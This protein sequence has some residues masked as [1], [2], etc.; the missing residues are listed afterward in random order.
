MSRILFVSL[1]L[2][3]RSRLVWAWVLVTTLVLPIMCRSPRSDPLLDRV[4]LSILLVLWNLKLVRVTLVLLSERRTILSCRLVG[5]LGLVWETRNVY[6][7]ALLC[8]MWLCSRR[9]RER[10]HWLVLKTMT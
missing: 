6:E 9:N 2:V 10:L 5:E 8:F 3:V 7:P 4:L 1:G